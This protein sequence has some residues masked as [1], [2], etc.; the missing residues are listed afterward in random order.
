VDRPGRGWLVGGMML[1][2]VAESELAGVVAFVNSAYRGDSARRGWSHEADLL[3]GARID[4]D[5]LRA[6]L[7]RPG[8]RLLV[9][10]KDAADGLLGC[11]WLEPAE[12]GAWYLGMLAVRPDLQDRGLG[13]EILAGAEAVAAAGGARRVRMTVIG[14]RGSLI[15]WYRRR[16]YAATGETQAFP[17]EP[18]RADLRFV[19]LE[20][21]VQ[22]RALPDETRE[23]SK[24]EAPPQTPPKARLWKPLA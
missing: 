15:A 5:M 18:A 12:D 9:L 1:V 11:V 8:A 22:G 21:A 3:D 6:D 19:V 13:R 2:P 7:A 23:A 14:V 24:V 10:R 16:G 17:G 20:K 4:E